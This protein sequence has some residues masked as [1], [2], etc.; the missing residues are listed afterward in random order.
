MLIIDL[1]TTANMPAHLEEWPAWPE[2]AA[3]TALP[4][5]EAELLSYK[6]AVVAK[7]GEEA[8]VKS[9]LSVCKTLKSLTDKIAEKG[10]AMLP[11]VS[12]DEMCN[13]SHEKQEQM[14][15]V[16]GFVVR[17]VIPQEEAEAHFTSLK[18]FVTDNKHKITGKE[19]S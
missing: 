18:T 16:G 3:P 11:E 15:N 19:M 5:E 1:S 2:F 7:F 6:K 10:T 17:G 4:K 12:Y 14:K 9:W 8:I 13:L